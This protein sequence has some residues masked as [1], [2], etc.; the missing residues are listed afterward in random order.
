MLKAAT[1]LPKIQT[2]KFD[3]NNQDTLVSN[4]ALKELINLLQ[5]NKNIERL[6]I[7]I[8]HLNV[9]DLMDEFTSIVGKLENLEELEL[10]LK[11]SGFSPLT[12]RNLGKAIVGL[13]KLRE[14]GLQIST[15]S[16]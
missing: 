3:F 2:F 15:K 11:G 1:S 7:I 9:E 12:Y 10:T 14:L 5:G 13:S 4:D 8:A 16:Q 6:S